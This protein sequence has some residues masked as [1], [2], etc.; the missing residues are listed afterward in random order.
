MRRRFLLS[1]SE[2]RRP[3]STSGPAPGDSICYHLLECGAVHLV[4]RPALALW[5]DTTCARA[6]PRLRTSPPSSAGI[7]GRRTCACQA[8][9][10]VACR[11]WSCQNGQPLRWGSPLLALD[12]WCATAAQMAQCEGPVFRATC[13]TS[14]ARRLPEMSTVTQEYQILGPETRLSWSI[15]HS[16][17]GSFCCWRCARYHSSRTSPC[18]SAYTAA[19]RRLWTWN[20]LMMLRR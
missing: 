9:T 6:H 17:A 16:S 8:G 15:F 3:A 20:L 10:C 18:F 4:V 19:S 11:L 13:Q 12:L 2:R 1:T 14:W 7:I 5:M